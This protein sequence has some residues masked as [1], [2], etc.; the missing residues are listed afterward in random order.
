[1]KNNE[2]D[3]AACFCEVNSNF[4]NDFLHLEEE[5]IAFSTVH[6]D[7]LQGILGSREIQNPA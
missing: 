3:S 6:D 1:M 5:D 2:T 4:E 7:V